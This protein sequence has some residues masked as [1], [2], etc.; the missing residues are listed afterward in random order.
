MQETQALSTDRED[1]LEK[2]MA[3]HS[4]C[5]I[6]KLCLTLCDPKDCSLPGSSVHE[7]FQARILEW[8]A[9]SF[10]RRSSKPRDQTH[11]S[12]VGKGFLYH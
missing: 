12:C 11:I 2:E 10:S 9:I 5:L 1:P 8:I 6:A 4:S 7:I 3:T